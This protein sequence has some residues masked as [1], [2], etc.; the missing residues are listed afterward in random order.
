[1]KAG[2]PLIGA[3]GHED[4]LRVVKA[5]CQRKTAEFHIGTNRCLRKVNRRCG[6]STFKSGDQVIFPFEALNLPGAKP[7]QHKA[8]LEGRQQLA[9]I[10]D[11]V[12]S[13]HL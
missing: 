9:R 12:S 5:A 1:M 6:C 11:A 7:Q 13:F 4:F 3:A 8:A 2:I 10:E